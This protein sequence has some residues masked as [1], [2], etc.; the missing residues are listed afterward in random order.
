[1]KKVRLLPRL[2]FLTLL[3]V[4]VAS[5]MTAAI[6]SSVGPKTFANERVKELQLGAEVVS[7][8]YVQYQSGEITLRGR[9]LPIGGLK[10]KLLAAKNAGIKTVIVPEKNRRDV[11]EIS[12]EIKKGLQIVY[13]EQMEDVLKIAFHE[14]A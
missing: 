2:L 14:K 4:V 5:V 1:M 8:Y 9:V 6:Y 10:E 11:A 7:T 12:A 3:A 13:A